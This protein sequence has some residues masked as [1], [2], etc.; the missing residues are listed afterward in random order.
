MLSDIGSDESGHLKVI[1]SKDSRSRKN[2][3]SGM[4]LGLK[5]K[6]KTVS[7]LYHNFQVSAIFLII[8]F[9]RVNNL[10][11]I[12]IL[13]VDSFYVVVTVSYLTKLIWCIQERAQ[14]NLD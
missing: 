9:L 2:T 1:N 5:H 12:G 13:I 10:N 8:K 6:L 14:G 3:I 7:F 4:K 11:L